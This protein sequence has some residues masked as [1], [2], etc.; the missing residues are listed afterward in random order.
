MYGC[1]KEIVAELAEL[2]VGA[3]RLWR[4]AFW[5]AWPEAGGDC[6][7]AVALAWQAFA[8]EA[9]G[10][11]EFRLEG[12][13]RGWRGTIGAFFGGLW[14]ELTGFWVFLRTVLGFRRGKKRNLVCRDQG[15]VATQRQE[16]KGQG[17]AGVDP[18]NME[19]IFTEAVAKGWLKPEQRPWA[20]ALARRD[21]L[22]L[23]EFFDLA[24]AA[25]VFQSGW[26][27]RRQ[28]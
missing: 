22:A 14:P 12:Q 25:S 20:E 4:R 24:A 16:R 13:N 8:L 5:Q 1:P 11:R 15:Q 19:M 3:R 21:W 2:P 18:E 23:K 7:R 9:K 10:L 6:Q 17:S 28:G 27:G 26:D